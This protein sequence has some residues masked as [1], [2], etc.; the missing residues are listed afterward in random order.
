MAMLI[1]IKIKPTS[2]IQATA[3]TQLVETDF[4]TAITIPPMAIR[5]A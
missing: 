3:I 1:R 5:G 4:L 2:T